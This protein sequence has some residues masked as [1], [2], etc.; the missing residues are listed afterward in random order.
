V[1]VRLTGQDSERGTFS[2]RHAVLHDAQSGERW[3]PLKQLRD[4]VAPF[5]LHNSPLSEQGCLGFE[6]G[7]SI[8]AADALVLWEAQFGDFVNSAQVIVDQFLVSGLAKWGQ[9]SRLTLLLPHGYEGSGPEHS[10][11]RLERFLQAAAEGN[12][13]VANCTTPAQYFHLLRRQALVSKPRPLV[14]MTPKSLLRLSAATSTVAELAEGAFE[15]V[16][17]DDR[18]ADDDDRERVTKLVLCSGKVYYDIVGHEERASAD[19]IAVARVEQLYP[20]PEAELSELMESYPRLERVAWVQEEPRNMGARAFMRRRMA[21]ILPEHLS[22][23]YVGRQLRAATGEGYSAAHKR[24]QARIVRVALDLE[25][26]RLEPDASAR[27]PV[28]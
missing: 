10:S 20:F 8:Q 22:Y 14:V 18:F 21:G 24:E 13:R 17:D 2:Q 16:I 11:A 23:D 3:C 9:T 26:D 25:E 15:R 19:H 6:Y 5:E 28:I 7:Y 12:I 27:R 4:G 1:P